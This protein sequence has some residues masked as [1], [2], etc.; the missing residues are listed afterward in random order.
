MKDF[1]NKNALITGSSQG[2]GL[3]IA[4]TLA[5][6][7]AA[8]TL[9]YPREVDR[10]AAE[11]AVLAIRDAGGR[12]IA[13]MADITRQADIV[14]LFDE[15][16]AAHGRL[17]FVVAN[18]GGN[19]RHATLEQ[20][21]EELWD[22]VNALNARSTFFIFQQAAARLNDNGRIVG[23]SSSTTRLP[24]PGTAIYAGAK[25][26]IEQYCK[27]ISKE[28]GHRG[29]TVNSVAPGMTDTEGLRASTVPMERYDIVKS[30]TPLGRV[31]LAQD[32]AD[33]VIMVLGRDAHWLTGQHINA[34]GGAFH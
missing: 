19:I 28:I 1:E 3:A 11:A 27:T 25:A 6:R 5:S 26:A 18:A 17:D 30:I 22:A 14:R 34:G 7:G 2:I 20:S 24:Y 23:M 9:N 10:N 33:T 12:A 15:A 21:T 13:V 8:V 29:I 32:V 31:G 16:E 4:R